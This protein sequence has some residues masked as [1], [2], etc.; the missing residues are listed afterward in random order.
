MY[1]QLLSAP[2]QSKPKSDIWKLLTAEYCKLKNQSPL[3]KSLRELMGT[4]PPHCELVQLLWPLVWRI[5][6]GI[7]KKKKNPTSDA[8]VP[9]SGTSPKN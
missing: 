2:Q 8:A 7:K 9:L 3:S 4:S 1:R 5:L 6:Q